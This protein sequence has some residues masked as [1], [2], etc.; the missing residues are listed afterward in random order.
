MSTP[1]IW[2][3]EIG[4]NWVLLITTL[5]VSL[6]LLN[7]TGS[8][9]AEDLAVDA[10]YWRGKLRISEK[11]KP[12]KLVVTETKLLFTYNGSNWEVPPGHVKTIYV[13]LS[14]H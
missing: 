10:V 4:R 6:F 11:K 1:P 7:I 14:R 2:F 12:G 5:I 9:L 8:V 3:A 13:S